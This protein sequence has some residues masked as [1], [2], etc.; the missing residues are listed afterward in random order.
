MP[1]R[2]IRHHQKTVCENIETIAR[3]EQSLLDE[4]TWDDKVIDAISAVFGHKTFAYLNA[5]LFVLWIWWNVSF[6]KLA[7]DPYPFQFLTLIVSLEAIFLSIF[8]LITQNRQSAISERRA[9]IDLQLNLLDEQESTA[10]L[11]ILLKISQHLG[12]DLDDLPEEMT[13]PIDMDEMVGVLD[14]AFRSK[15]TSDS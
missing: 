7:I 3:L 9:H 6:E 2:S 8:I 1:K 12:V 14:E 10:Q 11:K 13:Q 15:K 4:R 5:L